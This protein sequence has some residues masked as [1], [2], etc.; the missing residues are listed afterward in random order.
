MEILHSLGI[1]PQ[2]VVAQAIGFVVLLLVVR[3]F[4]FAPVSDILQQREEQIA[5]N[6]ASAEAQQVKAE[7]LRKEYEAHLAQIADEARAKFE[8]TMKDAEAARQRTLQHTQ[9]EI[10]ELY[11]RH[12]TQLGLERDQ[13]RRELRAEM[14]DIAVLAASKALH[15]QITP[16]IQ[17]AVIDQVISELDALPRQHA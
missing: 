3:K 8:Q 9:D 6:L 17:A 5:N 14:S 15:G 1:E 11:Q 12:E 2:V 7:S 16:T 13:L 10:R 4:L